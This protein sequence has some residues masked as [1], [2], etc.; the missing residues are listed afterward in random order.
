M[1]FKV[2]DYL[3]VVNM[4]N[5]VF[6]VCRVLGNGWPVDEGGFFVNPKNCELYK[7]ALSAVKAANNA[8]SASRE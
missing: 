3:K 1:E 4:P 5:K 6:R 8:R 2:G 7:G